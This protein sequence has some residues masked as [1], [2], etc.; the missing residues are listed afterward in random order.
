MQG[1]N[2][3]AVLDSIMDYHYDI[4]Y[5]IIDHLKSHGLKLKQKD[6]MEVGPVN[7]HHSDRPDHKSDDHVHQERDSGKRKHHSIH[8]E[9][10]I[11]R[12]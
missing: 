4:P 8:A 1:R 12:V 7:R 6:P 5:N 3:Q 9:L 2:E 10:S 11:L